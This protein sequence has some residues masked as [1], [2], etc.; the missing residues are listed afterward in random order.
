MMRMYG[1]WAIVRQVFF[2]DNEWVET[3]LQ[4]VG[5]AAS[6]L[7]RPTVGELILVKGLEDDF[8]TGHITSYDE[9]LELH[10]TVV[11]TIKLMKMRKVTKAW[12]LEL[13]PTMR[14][15]LKTLDGDD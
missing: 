11:W 7:V 12:E 13:D 3:E 5:K 6:L 2:T 9:S 1:H 14:E 10:S 15:L 8:Y 4:C